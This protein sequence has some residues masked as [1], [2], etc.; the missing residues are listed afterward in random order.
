[1]PAHCQLI[2]FSNFIHS[3][4]RKWF[5][6]FRNLPFPYLFPGSIFLICKIRLIIPMLVYIL[7]AIFVKLVILRHRICAPYLRRAAMKLPHPDLDQGHSW[8]SLAWLK[9][10]LPFYARKTNCNGLY[11]GIEIVQIFLSPQTL[12]FPA[13][14]C[15]T[16]LQ[17]SRAPLTMLLGRELKSQLT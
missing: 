9:R 8:H 11:N 16:F 1:M 4:F 12:Q 5:C 10:M 17:P 7:E 2:K 6:T 13:Y 14:D 15:T 3:H